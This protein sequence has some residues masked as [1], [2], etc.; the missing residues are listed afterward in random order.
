[1]ISFLREFWEDPD[2]KSS[3]TRLSMFGLT[4][5]GIVVALTWC[6]CAIVMPDKLTT[7]V[8]CG[9]GTILGALV[10]NGAVA[11]YQRTTKSDYQPQDH[12]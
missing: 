4:F 6:Y 10:T 9:F 12:S 11:L 7:Q 2:G 5:A 3:M 1:M 8:T